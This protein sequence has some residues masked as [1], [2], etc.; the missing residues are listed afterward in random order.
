MME[1]GFAGRHERALWVGVKG[2]D[3]AKRLVFPLCLILKK[4]VPEE[5]RRRGGKPGGEKEAEIYSLSAA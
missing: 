1:G 4:S 2:P 5:T 3:S